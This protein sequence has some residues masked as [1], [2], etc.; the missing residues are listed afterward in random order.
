ME[1]MLPSL[2]EERASTYSPFLPVCQKT[3]R[4]LQVPVTK[5]D[6]TAGTIV[7]QDE[8]G[9]EVETPVTGGRCKLQWKPD[10][11]MN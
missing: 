6:P 5:Y 7:Y 2:R 10:W 4:V 8:D 3:G 1:V 9:S 11:G